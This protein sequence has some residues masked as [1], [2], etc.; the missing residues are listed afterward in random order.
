MHAA[1]EKGSLAEIDKNSDWGFEADPSLPNVLIMGDSISIGYTLQVRHILSGKANVF[2]PMKGTRPAN[3]SGTITATPKI[4]AWLKQHGVKWSVIHFN[5]GL[6]DLKHVEKAGT[7]TLSNDPEDPRQA[8]VEVYSDNL[9][10]IVKKLKKT[11]A[12]LIFATTTPI[13]PGTLNPLRTP[14][15]PSLY[16]EAAMEIM[17]RHQIV[18]ND[19]YAFCEPQL[20]EIQLPKNC[21]FTTEGST[22]M[23]KEVAAAILSQLEPS[24]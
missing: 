19:L 11:K 20:K 3:C 24:K 6:H 10:A 5:W 8:S 4:E 7:H 9:E 1:P 14:E 17:D 21:H 13:A 22:A 2:R 16:N 18:V 23:A 12:K 15:A